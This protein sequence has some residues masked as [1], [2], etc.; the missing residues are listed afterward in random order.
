VA[1]DLENLQTRRSA[2]LAELAAI[3]TSSAGGLPNSQ[4]GGIDHIGYKRGLYEELEKIN[5]MIAA[6]EGPWEVISE[7]QP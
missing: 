5:Q 1:T 4:A 3:D 6:A 2:I 7:L